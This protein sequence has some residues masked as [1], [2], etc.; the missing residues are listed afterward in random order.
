MKRI[1]T[2]LALAIVAA[3]LSSCGCCS[4]EAPAPPLRPLPQF[5][6]IPQVHY[7]K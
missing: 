7:G 5:S 2:I 3:G 6:E 1:I 4:G